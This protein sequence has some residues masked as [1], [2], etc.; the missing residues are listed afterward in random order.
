MWLTVASHIA[1]VLQAWLHGI[2]LKIAAFPKEERCAAMNLSSIA[3]KANFN[4]EKQMLLVAYRASAEG[5]LLP[6][7]ASAVSGCE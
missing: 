6:S 3:P 7:S 5:P 4:E 2:Y 1:T